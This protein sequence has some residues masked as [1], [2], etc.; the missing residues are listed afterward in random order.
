MK[1]LKDTNG[2]YINY[3]RKQQIRRHI[4]SAIVLL[5]SVIFITVMAV[6]L[7]VN[8][9]GD[10][11]VNYYKYYTSTVIHP[12]EDMNDLYEKYGFNFKNYSAFKKEVLFIN[13]LSSD[14]LTRGM[15]L[16]IPYYSSEFK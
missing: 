10:D 15:S 1:T 6:R 12:H 2:R 8:A 3:R 16:V 11:T 13:N 9:S 4:T 7:A 14:D 5:A